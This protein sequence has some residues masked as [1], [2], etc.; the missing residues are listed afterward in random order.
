VRFQWHSR[1][2]TYGRCLPVRVAR[3]N[4]ARRELNLSCPNARTVARKFLGDRDIVR[5]D[6]H[7]PDLD[8]GFAARVAQR[9]DDA[10]SEPAEPRVRHAYTALCTQTRVQ[11]DAMCAAGVAVLPW[12]GSGQPYRGTADLVRQLERTGTLYVYLTEVG[13]GADK[14]RDPRNPMLAPSGIEIDGHR[15]LYNDLLR[16]VHDFFGHSMFG[17]SFSLRGELRAGYAHFQMYSADAHPA[18]FNE[19]VAQICWFYA[20]PHLTTPDGVIPR[21]AQPGFVPPRV[22]P[23]APQKVLAFPDAFV[24]DYLSR[25]DQAP[26]PA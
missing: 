18:L 1:T 14:D 3:G 10:I 4:G 11:F 8:D 12:R 9:L 7:F 21:A 23:Y 17:D 6:G 26:V 13:Y 24:A 16:A 15:F 25:F 19:M 5:P 22:R 20:G 2:S